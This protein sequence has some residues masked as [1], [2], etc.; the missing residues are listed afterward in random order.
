MR[1]CSKHWLAV[2]LLCV[3]SGAAC[4]GKAPSHRPRR[5]DAGEARVSVDAT[6]TPASP[7]PRPRRAVAPRLAPISDTD[8]RR[9]E[10][11][12]TASVSGALSA[13]TVRRVFLR[14]IAEHKKCV[15]QAISRNPTTT[16]GVVRP[17]L[18]IRPDG[19]VHINKHVTTVLHAEA[20]RCTL[21]TVKRLK[22]PRAKG[23]TNV[24][25]PL[26]YDARH[27]AEPL[28][29]AV[30]LRWQKEGAKGTPPRVPFS[31]DKDYDE[32]YKRLRP[33]K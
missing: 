29:N 6:M 23:T 21:A 31:C 1:A 9:A 15:L 7:R 27:G 22:F 24:A 13:K 17:E 4:A 19:T 12:N 5:A 26:Y 3:F 18:V 10:V 32:V 25:Y 14:S 2:I 8:W 28:Y 16:F 20:V 33:G 11:L 30:I